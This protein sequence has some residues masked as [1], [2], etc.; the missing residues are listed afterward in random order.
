MKHPNSGGEIE[1]QGII[2]GN[3][4]EHDTIRLEKTEL[5]SNHD[6][7]SNGKLPESLQQSTTTEYPFTKKTR[8]Q[9]ESRNRQTRHQINPIEKKNFFH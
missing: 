4:Q 1:Q 5:L 8:F 9:R 7:N 3:N 2:D 6:D